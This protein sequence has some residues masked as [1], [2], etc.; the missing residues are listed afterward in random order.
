MSIFFPVFIK[1]SRFS[2]ESSNTACVLL[3]ITDSVFLH[4]RSLKNRPCSYFSENLV[5]SI[6]REIK[7]L[8][9]SIVLKFICPL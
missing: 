7:I 9:K 1:C 8:S 5:L 3:C 4:L 6:S 2:T